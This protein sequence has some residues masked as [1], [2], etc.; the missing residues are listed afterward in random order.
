MMQSA[1][2]LAKTVTYDAARSG[3]ASYSEAGAS[4][5]V[6]LPIGG[7]LLLRQYGEQYL[8]EFEFYARQR[9]AGLAPGNR[10]RLAGLVYDITAIRDYAKVVV[11]LLRRAL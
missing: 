4:R 5:G 10:L 7:E 9:N 3:L 1:T 2:V 6:L 11:C 8:G